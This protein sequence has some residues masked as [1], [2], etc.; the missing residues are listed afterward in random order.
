[1]RTAINILVGIMMMSAFSQCANSRKAISQKPDGLEL[2]EVVSEAW[3]M[4]S[5]PES[6]TNLFIPVTSANGIFLD[7]VFYKGR[8]TALEKVQRGSYLVYI[9]RFMDSSK[10]DIV[11]HADPRKEA[12]N[13]P[14]EIRKPIPFELA[15]DEAVVSFKEGDVVKYFKIP[16]VKE[17]KPV[18]NPRKE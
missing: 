2:G 1:M 9:G 5:S 14:P 4:E 16:H 8:R 7:S 11:M 18:V 6:G 13:R 12:G 10:P 3:T 17:G 15:E